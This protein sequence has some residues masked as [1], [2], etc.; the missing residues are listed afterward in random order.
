[1]LFF[2]VCLRC[3]NRQLRETTVLI[4]EEHIKYNKEPTRWLKVW[5]DGQLKFTLHINE[6]ISK[7]STAKIQIKGLTRTYG[8]APGLVRQI[9]IAAVQSITLYGAEL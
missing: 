2:K 9:Q 5:L 4:A 3:C 6:R 7:A 8:V 1:M